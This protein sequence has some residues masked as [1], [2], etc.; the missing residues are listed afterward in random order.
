MLN[1]KKVSLL[2]MTTVLSGS[3]VAG[4]GSNAT[5]AKPGQTDAVDNNETVT[6][7]VANVADNSLQTLQDT[8]R[9]KFPNVTL[10]QVKPDDPNPNHTIASLAQK[11]ATFDLYQVGRQT[12]LAGLQQ[13]GYVYDMTPLINKYKLDL[14]QFDQSAL[15]AN[16]MYMTPGQMWDL[17]NGLNHTVMAYNKDIFD[18]FGVPYPHDGMTWSQA[19]D[20]A[21]KMTRVDG[22]KQYHGLW[23]ADYNTAF[24]DEY[25]LLGLDPKTNQSVLTTDPKWQKVF[26]LYDQV[27][28]IPGN[29]DP[30]VN[31]DIF[32]GFSVDQNVAMIVTFAGWY[33]LFGGQTGGAAT[34]KNFHLN[35]D[36][37]SVP[38]I[39]GVGT[40]PA[41]Q[42]SGWAVAPQSQNKDIAFRIIQYLTTDPVP[43][44]QMESGSE[45]TPAAVTNPD[46]QKAFA[47]NAPEFN[48]KN[49]PAVFYGKYAVWPKEVS[50][51]ESTTRGTIIGVLRAE[52]DKDVNTQLRDAEDALNKAVATLKQ[53]Q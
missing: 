7:T 21:T 47:T 28:A 42:T 40:E 36:M 9:K 31:K 23:L 20:L 5:G 22:G 6:I 38:T 25:P 24:S 30:Q 26:S 46:V 52:M 43:L 2:A 33:H 8:I 49:K 48:G 10:Q 15:S 17:P 35:W 18:K 32:Q 44:D 11:G 45:P 37:V 34:D 3:I 19:I 13:Y 1:M 16:T 53:Q 12:D 4:C 27:Y 50:P 41:R 29:F 14:N 51:Y 39:D